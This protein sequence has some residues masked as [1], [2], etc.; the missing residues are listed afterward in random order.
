MCNFKNE[1]WILDMKLTS[2]LHP[3]LNRFVENGPSGCSL[4]VI[5]HGENIFEDYLGYADLETKA[6]ISAESI[7]RIHSMTKVVTCTAALMLYER[8]M[9]L[10][11]DPLEEYLPEFKNIHVYQ[12]NDQGELYSATAKSSIKIK[13]LFMM[14]SGLTYPGEGDETER[15]TGIKMEELKQANELTN[16]N[17]SKALVTIPLAFEPGSQ[18]R[19]GLSHDVLGALIEGISGKSLGD[20]LQENIF[21]R[22]DMKDSFFRVPE[23]KKHRLVSLYNRSEEGELSKNV[24]MDEH[25]QPNATYESGGAGLLS[26]L[27]DYSRFAHMLANGGSWKEERIIGEKTIN[28]MRMNHLDSEQM[29]YYNWDHLQGYGYGLGVRTLIDPVKG[30]TNSSVGEFGWL[31]LAGTWVMIDPKEKISAVYMQQMF[32]NFEGYHQPRLR[33]VIYGSL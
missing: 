20:F 24:S 17:L 5:H 21:D 4:K 32:P 19:Y 3:L 6:L 28:L 8:G 14:T 33:A 12:S 30:G 13:D 25:I 29:D 15:K 9:F 23:D 1:R 7:F 27:N 2:K 18:W 16:R 26:T 11:N 22:L 10:L 31:G